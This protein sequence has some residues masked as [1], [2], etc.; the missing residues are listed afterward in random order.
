MGLNARAVAVLLAFGLGACPSEDRE[1]RV[2]AA[3]G[4][5]GAAPEASSATDE[6]K[7]ERPRLVVS[8]VLDQLGSWVLERYRPLLPEDGLLSRGMRE[9]AFHLRVRYPYAA[10]ITAAG[11][12]TL[13]T[14]VTPRA[15]GV[16]ANDR[17]DPERGEKRALVDDGAHP[18]LGAEGYAG[19]GVLRSPT[20]ADV[21]SAATKGR[22]K[23]VSISIKDR[24][25]ILTAGR[26]PD[27]VA[28]Y[29][30]SVPGFTTSTY[31]A[32]DLPPW[33]VA[34]RERHPVQAYFEPW[35]PL[36]VTRQAAMVPDDRAVEGLLEGFG[37]TF[38][39][40]PRRT[41]SPASIFRFMPASTRYQLDLARAAVEALDLGDDATPDL[42]LL[43]VSATDYIGHVFGAE[44]WE[45]LDNL[46]RTDRMLS[47]FVAELRR[48]TQVAVVVTSDHGQAPLPADPPPPRI[49]P[50]AL[51]QSIESAL[52]AR[53]GTGPFAAGY[54]LPYIYLTPAAMM[55][56]EGEAL[57]DAMLAHLRERPDI[58]L[59]VRATE[60]AKWIDSRDPMKRAIAEG[61]DLEQSGSIYL[62][63]KEG[64]IVDPGLGGGG[65]THGTPYLYDR[66][67][68]V[69][70]WGAGVHRARTVEPQDA[71]QVAP[72]LAAL[73][74]ISPPEGATAPTLA[75]FPKRAAR[76][77][78]QARGVAPASEASG[79]R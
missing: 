33:F 24:G 23:I 66:D 78:G 11:H 64:V 44:S 6:R 12:A 5:A 25:A 70:A 27:F 41:K 16:V 72:S 63:P 76:G 10:T 4:S 31:Y 68:P 22:A 57:V 48:E 7:N 77:E 9:G 62:V 15:H 17:Y 74:G 21:L 45:Y 37:R 65:T 2:K 49:D 59:A 56:P 75:G 47:D 53:F 71:L 61:I 43:S 79:A 54:F 38:P 18:I 55:H 19:P 50:P 35:V 39:H 36:P 34:F 32:E 13:H 29:D 14:G 8:I 1:G 46:L 67:V 20:V 28:F 3:G 40:D 69:I 73:L 51:L 26:T 60:A 30:R 42:L 52:T 58:R